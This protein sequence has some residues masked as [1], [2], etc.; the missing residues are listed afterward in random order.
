MKKIIS[1]RID[2]DLI[3]LFLSKNLTDEF[4]RKFYLI[5]KEK[6]NPSE[7]LHKNKPPFDR[8]VLVESQKDLFKEKYLKVDKN[9]LE[10]EDIIEKAA[11]GFTFAS[12][13]K[14]RSNISE[15]EVLLRGNGY[16]YKWKENDLKIKLEISGVHKKDKQTFN[17]RVYE[18]K[19]KFSKK[20]FEP[21]AN[22]EL[23][24]VVDFYHLRYKLW[25]IR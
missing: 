6:D 2:K 18:K 10:M 9:S 15:I 11:I 21:L 23:I 5:M 24:S 17:K 19:K 13:F 4:I 14:L 12:F 22:E 1:I 20:K 7:F 3:Q 25:N 8:D 16:D